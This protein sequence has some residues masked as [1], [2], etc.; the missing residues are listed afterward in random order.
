MPRTDKLSL[1]GGQFFAVSASAF[2]VWIG[3]ASFCV[4][5]SVA[6]SRIKHRTGSLHKQQDTPVKSECNILWNR[7]YLSDSTCSVADTKAGDEEVTW[8]KLVQRGNC[9]V[10][11][12]THLNIYANN[13][14][15]GR[16]PPPPPQLPIAEKGGRAAK[17]FWT[18]AS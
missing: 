4:L 8:V 1:N 17:T 15:A 9:V 13:G 14:V 12:I 6:L 7:F 11:M 2:D 10:R 18:G 16:G 3:K 5:K